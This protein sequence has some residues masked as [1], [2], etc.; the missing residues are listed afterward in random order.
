LQILGKIA[1]LAVATTTK[2]N[3]DIRASVTFVAS[4]NIY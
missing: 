4:T 3:V 2:Q 1:N